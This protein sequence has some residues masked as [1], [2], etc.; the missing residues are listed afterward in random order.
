[1]YFIFIFISFYRFT[2]CDNKVMYIRNCNQQNIEYFKN[3]FIN[4]NWKIVLTEMTDISI[5]Y[6]DFINILNDM[7]KKSVF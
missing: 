4:I 2:K 1:M 3:D 5:C 6:I 7:V